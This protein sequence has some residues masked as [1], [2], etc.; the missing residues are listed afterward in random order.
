MDLDLA[1]SRALVTAASQGLGRAC[2]AALAAE[3]A[4]V[5][6]SSRDQGR[7]EATAA[8]IGAAG[9]VAADLGSAADLEELVRRTVELL[10][11][12]D[13]LVVNC[14]P[15]PALRFI[16][17]DD[18]AWDAAHDGVLMSAVRLTRAALPH[19]R[20]SG[21]GRVVNLTGY[22]TKE[23]ISQLV[24][25][26]ANRASVT[27]LAKVLADDLAADGVTVNNIAPGPILTDRLRELQ[28]KAAA[29]AGVDLDEQLRRYAED[30]PV[31]RLGR[32]EEIGDLCAF[33]CSPRAGF[34]TGQTI[35][36]DGGIN[37]SI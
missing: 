31:R 36:V 19:L 25:S 9:S 11:G 24:L 35:V 5:V 22:G 12:L 14:G 6:I 30:I 15:P 32:P 34:V 37:R 1:G 8:E 28:G 23:P 2:A 26:E 20:E 7:L 27:V 13:V 10:G 4:R 29:S 33:L 3:G 16:E 17:A 21:R 18:G